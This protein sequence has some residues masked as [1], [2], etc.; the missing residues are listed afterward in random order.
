[1]ATEQDLVALMRWFT[2]FATL[3]YRMAR[4]LAGKGILTR[5][6]YEQ[7]LKL[8]CNGV[9][10]T[11]QI[12]EEPPDV[13]DLIVWAHEAHTKIQRLQEQVD[14]LKKQ[15]Q[16]LT[17][18]K[19]TLPQVSLPLYDYPRPKQQKFTPQPQKLK[20]KPVMRKEE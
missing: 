12:T 10:G 9:E 5:E 20:P 1:M 15:V 18:I 7:E 13:P 14:V 6:E 17:P 16:E 8:I 3:H 2:N 11:L 19:P 4:L